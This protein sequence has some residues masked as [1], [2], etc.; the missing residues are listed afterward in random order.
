[1]D[2]IYY[3]LLLRARLAKLANA[4]GLGPST[5]RFAGSSPASRTIFRIVPAETAFSRPQTV[6][7]VR[8]DVAARKNEIA[9]IRI[10]GKG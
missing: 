7:A 5:E 9:R 6:H 3:S 8:A 10:A 2:M 4:L 1:M